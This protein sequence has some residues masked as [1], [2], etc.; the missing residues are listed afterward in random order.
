[1][2]NVSNSQGFYRKSKLLSNLVVGVTFTNTSV[3]T[4][5]R[6]FSM[7]DFNRVPSLRVLSRVVPGPS[8]KVHG[9]VHL[10]VYRD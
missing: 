6:Y 7:S 2:V 9:E 3:K 8:S 10:S 4:K 1:M 5:H